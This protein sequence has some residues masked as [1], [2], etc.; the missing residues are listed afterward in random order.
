M[1]LRAIAGRASR[2]RRGFSLAEAVV[3][4]G[5][6]ATGLSGALAAVSVAAGVSREAVAMTRA[7]Q[8]ARRW[9]AQPGEFAAGDAGVWFADA[10]GAEIRQ[11]EFPGAVFRI[12]AER[13]GA[14][15]GGR[16]AVEC[17]TISWPPGRWNRLRLMTARA[18]G[19]P[20]ARP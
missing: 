13:C 1:G 15:A 14:S 12:Q 2:R 9:L 19:G 8:I 4:L 17:L 6:A 7:T 3:A 16:C 18:G 11:G 10:E 5:V 20:G